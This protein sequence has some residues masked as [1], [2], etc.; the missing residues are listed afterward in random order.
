MRRNVF[1]LDHDNMEEGKQVEIHH[2]K[3]QP[4][5]WKVDMVHALVRHVVDLTP[6]FLVAKDLPSASSHS[7]EE[8]SL[9]S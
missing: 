9:T 4:N 6:R 1:W 7:A 8:A 3:S 5:D 2:K